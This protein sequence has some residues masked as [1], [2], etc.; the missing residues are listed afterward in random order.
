MSTFGK[1]LSCPSSERV[2]GY[3][4]KSLSPSAAR[5]VSAH[6]ASCDFCGAE[7]SFM[8]RHSPFEDYTTGPTPNQ[9]AGV[10]TILV[11][12]MVYRNQERHAA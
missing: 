12:Q 4:T 2:L 8:S 9:M 7:M 11:S 6:V 10:E 3:I 1:K 5:H